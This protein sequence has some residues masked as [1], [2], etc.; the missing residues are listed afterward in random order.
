[1]LIPGVDVAFEKRGCHGKLE[2]SQGLWAASLESVAMVA[3]EQ[4]H[5]FLWFCHGTP[6]LRRGGCYNQPNEGAQGSGEQEYTRKEIQA[7]TGWVAQTVMLATQPHEKG[8]ALLPNRMASI[9]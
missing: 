5:L 1:M 4:T 2:D 8:W 3:M 9:F 7:V 6:C